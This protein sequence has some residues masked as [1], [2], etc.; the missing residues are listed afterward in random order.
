MFSPPALSLTPVPLG[1][2]LALMSPTSLAQPTQTLPD[3]AASTALPHRLMPA[4]ATHTTAGAQASSADETAP[5]I[6]SAT[7][8]TGATLDTIS[9]RAYRTVTHTQAA[10]KTDTPVAETPQSVSVIGRDE[11]DARGV[12]TLNEAMRYV[13]G[14]ALE[15]TGVD[16]R[17]DDFRIRGFDAGS[18]SNNVTLDGMRAPQGTQF[19]RTAIDSWALERIEVLKGPSALLYGQMSPG[20]MVNQVS[21]TPEPDLPTTV[22]LGVDG[23]GQLQGAFDV[24]GNTADNGH[25]FR[26]NGLVRKGP[27]QIRE[28]RE[29]RLML[30]PSYTLKLAQRSR[31]TLL[32]LYQRDRGG[33]TYQFLPQ[34]GTLDATP[35]GR[36]THRT[37]LGVP[38]FNTYNRDIQSVGWLFEH[39]LD[40]RWTLSQSAR[41]LH[42]D[43]LYRTAV[44]RGPLSE[45]GRTQN[46]R[47][48][49][50]EGTSR[51]LTI[52]T[53]LQG[54]LRTGSLNHTAL[55]GL[56][57]QK[58]DVKGDRIAYNNPS[59]VDI[60]NPVQ[61]AY[62]PVPQGA[63]L[64]RE[65]HTQTGLYLQ[66]QIS[67][68]NWRVTLGG[69]HDWTRDDGSTARHIHATG[70]TSPWQQDRIKDKAFSGQTGVLY[71]IGNGF[72]PYASYAES[73]QPSPEG[74]SMNID[75]KPFES[76]RGKQFEIGTKY[77]PRNVDGLVTLSAY[78]LQQDNILTQDPD[79][80]HNTCG[81]GVAQCRIQGGKSRVRGIELEGRVTPMPGFSVI[82]ALSRMDST[83]LRGD[84]AH[85]GKRLAAVPDWTVALWADH[86]WQGGELDGLSLGGGIRYIG[87]SY[88]NETNTIHIP[89]HFLVDAAVRYDLDGLTGMPARLALNASNLANRQFI[90]TCTSAASC[91]FGSGR[92]ITATL[93]LIW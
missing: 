70:R 7:T 34:A 58:A 52:D 85:V 82:G 5:H 86:R 57:W 87:A 39:A 65:K 73:F 59:P 12:R 48:I 55:V 23:H 22:Q 54:K 69:R 16:N 10:T 17:V 62:T 38:S 90:S 84:S 67:V 63:M 80:T 40:D 91:H 25:L 6:T 27:T 79:P 20:G 71:D 72:L 88:G 8:D 46:R 61:T 26:L 89:S 77:Q 30:A 35:F 43:S 36:I 75:R 32:G 14:V 24:G 15:S 50:S 83:I 4:T 37:F 78:E 76:V 9:V 33:S 47:A 44:T 2:A 21:K 53:R 49:S 66:D 74:S 3:P 19:N 42:V 56:D 41:Y 60:F 31:L 92:T 1:I 45:D 64:Y 29:E 68:G 81:T 93:S 11:L 28:T 18:W 51:G 13:S